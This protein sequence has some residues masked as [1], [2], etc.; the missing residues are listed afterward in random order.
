VCAGLPPGA[1]VAE[2]PPQSAIPSGVVAGSRY[3]AGQ[4]LRV[5]TE[6]LNVRSQPTTSQA[7]V[8]EVLAR[9]DYVAIL[10]AP[11]RRRA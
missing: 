2:S 10:A 3:Q 9:G 7:N 1:Q 4:Q 11:I 8:V 6:A 5:Y